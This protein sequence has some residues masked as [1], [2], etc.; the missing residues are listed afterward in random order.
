MCCGA[1]GGCLRIPSSS[2]SHPAAPSR[3]WRAR[4]RIRHLRG[5]RG[6]HEPARYAWGEQIVVTTRDGRDFPQNPGRGPAHR[7]RGAE[8]GRH[9]PP[10][11]PLGKSTDLMIGE[12]VVRWDPFAYLLG[13]TEPTVTAGVVS[14]VGRNLLPRRTVGDLR[15]HDTN[16]R[17]HQPRQLGWATGERRGRRGGREQLDLHELGG[18]VG[19]GFAIP[20]ERALRVATSCDASGKYGAPGW[21]STSRSRGPAGMEAGGR[22]ARDPGAAGGPAGRAGVAAG[23][24]LVSARGRRLRTFLDWEAVMLDT[25]PGDTLVVSYRHAARAAAPGWPSPISRPRSRR[26]G[27]AGRHEGRDG[28]PGGASRT[29]HSEPT[30]A[31]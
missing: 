14:A 23:D 18:S 8:A 9:G 13:N 27:R 1:S 4:V 25:G 30:M 31:R 10:T 6:H 29:R 5:R 20:I 21:G 19:I 28:D 24:V 7:H 2:S 22:P 11:A 26:S 3:W 16:R 12:W 17:A 15:R